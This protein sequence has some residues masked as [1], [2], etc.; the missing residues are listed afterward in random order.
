LGG[1]LVA[2]AADLACGD[3]FAQE[4]NMG[5]RQPGEWFRVHPSSWFDD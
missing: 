2:R 5:F 4:V 3:F 1:C